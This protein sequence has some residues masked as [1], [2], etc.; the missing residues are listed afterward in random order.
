[1]STYK[2]CPKTQGELLLGAL[3]T[4]LPIPPSSCLP[5]CPSTF[6]GWGSQSCSHGIGNLPG[7]VP[8]D[9]LAVKGE[10]ACPGLQR[11]LRAC[12]Q[13]LPAGKQQLILK[14]KPCVCGRRGF[15]SPGHIPPVNERTEA[16]PGQAASADSKRPRLRQG[17]LSPHARL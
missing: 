10:D 11:T 8:Q 14:E 7:G 9:V 6:P 5:T 16:R 17:T 12:K 15:C 3:G 13:S 4:R 2:I 1:M